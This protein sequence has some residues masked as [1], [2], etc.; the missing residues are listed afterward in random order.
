MSGHILC[1]FGFG[2]IQAG[3]FVKEAFESG[4][5]SRMVVSEIDGE[6][7][8]AVRANGGSYYVNVAGAG[9]IDKLKVD[10]VELVNPNVEKDKDIL[11]EALAQSTE[12]VTSL[13]SVKFFD[14]GGDNNVASLTAEGLRK[15]EAEATI[16]YT[17]ENDNRAAE[18]LA[19]AVRRKAGGLKGKK[20]QFLNTVIGKMSQVVTNAA[21]IAERE[22]APIA[23]G[24]GRAFLVEEFNK[25]FV[26]RTTI[27]GFKPGVEVFIEKD[28]LLPFEEAKL[29]G[30][31]AIHAL[32]GFIGAVKG[33]KK[34]AE[35]KDDAAVMAIGREA[36]LRE[37][38]GALVR[39]YANLGDELFTE[40]GYRGFA[41]DLLERMTNPYLGDTVERTTRDVVRKLGIND[42]IFGTMSVA[43]EEGI[44]PVN[45]A[46]GA[47][48]GVAVLLERADEYGLPSELRF[49]DRRELGEERIEKV[50]NWVWS[51]HGGEY[52]ERLIKCACD[53]KGRLRSVVD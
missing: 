34:M 36:F 12:I 27:E 42:R 10:G 26:T 6:L 35:L 30:H 4:N 14:T 40:D 21:E 16:I 23:P 20:V 52:G 22:L 11:L 7:V 44:E 47:M 3:L 29:Y 41:E 5:F 50:L 37:S 17:A 45:M 31:N 51:G 33:Y 13:P 24:I 18:I 19:E 1:G 46:A 2:P 9:G 28:D 8:E 25:I 32:L 43:L 53:A 49:G 15:N 38:G 48:A 39:K